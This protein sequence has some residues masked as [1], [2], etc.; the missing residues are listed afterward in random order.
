MRHYCVAYALAPLAGEAE[1][2]FVTGGWQAT[3]LAR[4]AKV[5]HLAG[6]IVRYKDVPRSKVA[7]DQVAT[8][9]VGHAR[10]HVAADA[11]LGLHICETSR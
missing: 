5:R 7:V 2:G 1:R 8:G 6:E 11:D 9:Q 3:H 4:H 10:R